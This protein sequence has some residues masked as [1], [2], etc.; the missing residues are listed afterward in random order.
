MI[1]ESEL[2]IGINIGKASREDRGIT[3]Y[4]RNILREFGQSGSDYRFVLLH[5]PDSSP[6]SKF[7]IK[8]ADLEP[9]PYLDRLNPWQTMIGEQVLNPL[10]QRKLKLDVVW[11]PHNRGQFIVPVGYVCTM[12][13]ILP[14]SRPE[15]FSRC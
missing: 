6:E 12:H 11:H 9:L 3:V 8:D 13:D 1:K 10:Q 7:G 15:L 5:Y 2:R 4:T 14:V